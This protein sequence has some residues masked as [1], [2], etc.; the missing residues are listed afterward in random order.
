MHFFATSADGGEAQACQLKKVEKAASAIMRFII[1]FLDRDGAGIR[2]H[3]AVTGGVC[4]SDFS[5]ADWS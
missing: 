4:A 5:R 3:H 2:T 1:D